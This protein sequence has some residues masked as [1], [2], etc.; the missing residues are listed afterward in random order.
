MAELTIRLVLDPQSGKKNLIIGYE[1]EGDALPMEHEEEHKQLVERVLA[2][3]GLSMSDIGEVIVE[4]ET[5]AA[6]E[7]ETQQQPAEPQSLSED[8]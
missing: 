1:S 5:S 7:D 2:G 6:T 3:T 8:Q 4:R